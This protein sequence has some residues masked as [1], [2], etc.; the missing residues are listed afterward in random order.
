MLEAKDVDFR[1][2]DSSDVNFKLELLRKSNSMFHNDTQD[3]FQDFVDDIRRINESIKELKSMCLCGK[4]K[5]KDS[6]LIEDFEYHIECLIGEIEHTLEDVVTCLSS[7]VSNLHN[8]KS[9]QYGVNK[10]IDVLSSVLNKVL[11]LKKAIK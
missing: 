9:F 7:Y 8:I 11:E 4:E 3:R 5:K 6:D 10:Q 2:W 1:K